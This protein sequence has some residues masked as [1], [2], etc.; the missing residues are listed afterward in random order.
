MFC[1]RAEVNKMD[2]RMKAALGKESEGDHG[3]NEVFG[4]ARL[5]PGIL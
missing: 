2:A 4:K 3:K 5:V 1:C